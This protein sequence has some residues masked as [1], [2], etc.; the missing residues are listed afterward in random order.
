MEA[1]WRDK[2]SI[3]VWGV[4]EEVQEREFERILQLERMYDLLE[5]GMVVR[6]GNGK[7]RRFQILFGSPQERDA[8]LARL[9]PALQKYR[10]NAVASRD[11]IKRRKARGQVAGPGCE[12]G[13]SA[14][15]NAPAQRASRNAEKRK[16]QRL[17]SDFFVPAVNQ[18][19]LPGPLPRDLLSR[20]V[21]LKRC[22]MLRVATFNT[23][24]LNVK[25][26]EKVGEL[27]SHMELHGI[28][29]CAC[30]ETHQAN[31]PAPKV[32]GY[33]WYGKGHVGF[34]IS[35]ALSKVI[36]DIGCKSNSC[37][38]WIRIPGNKRFKDLYLCSVYMPQSANTIAAKEAFENLQTDYVSFSAKGQVVLLGDFNAH[39]GRP[40]DQNE[41]KYIGD[42]GPEENRN[43][44]GKRLM[45]FL[46]KCSAMSM[47]CRVPT[48]D[49][50]LEY[51]RQDPKTKAQTV[52]DYCIVSEDL[53]ANVEGVSVYK[54][55][56]DSD[57]RMVQMTLRGM[58]KIPRTKPTKV[59]KWRRSKLTK[60][61][62]KKEDAKEADANR[63]KW[64]E[65]LAECRE[66][67]NPAG[68]AGSKVG[69]AAVLN[70]WKIRV[71]KAGDE[72]IGR[73]V[74]IKRFSQK[75][76][77]KEVRAAIDH[78]R[79]IYRQYRRSGDL[80]D[81]KEYW[82]LRS[83]VRKLVARKRK[84]EW[85]SKLLSVTTEFEDNTKLFWSLLT[86]LTG[87]RAAL[88][89]G[90][91]RDAEGVLC[92]DEK[93]RSEAL[94]SFY[95]K[96]G[97]PVIQS[98]TIREDG[99]AVQI[100]EEQFT[101]RYDDE[102]RKEVEDFVAVCSQEQREE[103]E[104][105]HSQPFKL[106]EVRA[107][108]KKLGNGKAT[109][110]DGIPPE[111]LKY[112]GDSMAN[113]LCTL[114]NWILDAGHT[115][116]QWGKALVIL[117]YKKGDPTD[118]GNYRG[119]SLLDVVGKVFTRLVAQRIE[120]AVKDIIVRE[121]AGFTEGK[122][123]TEH[124][125]VLDRI[126]QARKKEGKNTYLFFLDVRK[127]FD[128]VW[129][130]GLLYKLWQAG[131][132]GKL[133]RIIKA[134]YAD[135]FSAILL[136][137]KASR[138][139]KILQGVRQG[140][141]ASPC[142]FKV[143]INELAVEL[144]AMNLGVSLGTSLERLQALLFADDIV[145]LADSLE[146]LQRM[147]DKVAR[148]TRKW[149]FQE[150]LGKCGIMKVLAT[151]RG[152]EAEVEVE[153]DV[154]GQATVEIDVG[155]STCKYFGEDVAVVSKYEY[156]G[157]FFHESGAWKTHAEKVM[158]KGA[159]AINGKWMRVFKNRQLPVK[160]RVKV[161]E[162]VVLPKFMYAT[163]VWY[164]P[165]SKPRDKIETLQNKVA[166]AIL[167]CNIKSSC[168]GTR[169]FLGFKSMWMRRAMRLLSWRGRMVIM[170][171]DCLVS[172][173]QRAQWPVGE[174]W[175]SKKGPKPKSL[176][177]ETDEWLKKLRLVETLERFQTRVDED[178]D[179]P[180]D[181]NRMTPKERFN[182]WVREVK[183]A[184][185]QVAKEEYLEE[186]NRRGS[187]LELMSYCLPEPGLTERFSGPLNGAKLI[188]A[189]F[190]LGTHALNKDLARRVRDGEANEAECIF[191]CNGAEEDV[192]HFLLD[193]KG[194]T[195]LRKKLLKCIKGS[196]WNTSWQD[197]W[198]S[199]S[200]LE[201]AAVLLGGSA[202]PVPDEI[203]AKCIAFLR[204]AYKVR[205][206]KLTAIA[207][208]GEDSPSEGVSSDDEA[209][210]GSDDGDDRGKNMSV[211]EGG[212]GGIDPG[213]CCGGEEEEGSGGDEGEEGEGEKIE[214]EGSSGD[215]SEG[216]GVGR[217]GAGWRG[218]DGSDLDQGD[219]SPASSSDEL[220]RQRRVLSSEVPP[221]AGGDRRRKSSD[222][223]ERWLAGMMARGYNDKLSVSFVDRDA[224]VADRS[225]PSF[226][227]NCFVFDVVG[228]VGDASSPS[229]VGANVNHDRA[230]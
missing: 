28:D 186:A 175:K 141:S 183:V 207:E 2:R 86:E 51:T 63:K 165:N 130:D 224:I 229:G 197:K 132:R 214:G 208:N 114:F 46:R 20:E 15:P 70:D 140:D 21:S 210:E 144:K 49:R 153:V 5:S 42:F 16:N 25:R 219:A 93:G 95:E 91:I 170:P 107:V 4:H 226:R 123:C 23:V 61:S 172:K 34:M 66:D 110:G 138:W 90:P 174:R 41:R 62:N 230:R 10:W 148:Y 22:K 102:F 38:W 212:E 111:F 71:E 215:D 80:R 103:E 89:S 218:E 82:R 29:V 157:V 129:R 171:R 54:T 64:R 216:G 159:K 124:I 136:D 227:T 126:I 181:D 58:K 119:I 40:K 3:V 59:V 199:K 100:G 74:V 225:G 88:C 149:R 26:M 147:I 135:N 53:A 161:W 152:E 12:R 105:A 223:H 196:S 78:R 209:E 11:Y 179:L 45:E 69:A 96:L 56:L 200:R 117:L 160:L 178:R 180:P 98:P 106:A 84:K 202:D 185:N 203:F 113:S 188:N 36:Q 167:H 133:W 35:L 48:K 50:S 9:A 8:Q 156:L 115:P 204:Q 79:R 217:R 131:V 81:L 228:V 168:V 112:G 18:Y 6:I 201:Q 155:C 143:F 33:R 177:V 17:L 222:N 221:P 101:H 67:F 190:R 150:N 139:F 1:N 30:Q 169:A 187:K 109:G 77:D 166:A 32:Q 24:A 104:D 97:L 206:A 37:Q 164:C 120:V 85:E 158:M 57:H 65:S 125:Y 211:A 19:A 52:I 44:N 99:K 116:E 189:R 92:V 184:A 176:E 191:G 43:A 193:C 13:E 75:W 55:D 7:G 121:Q 31:Q 27:T 76:F 128:T 162:T 108:L 47:N 60:R 154:D 195:S 146:D 205:S 182:A 151:K 142:L 194:Y 94:A 73:K 72:A 163:E 173:V 192:C 220:E 145:L 83:K 198:L 137:G 14:P 122:G 87:G 39:C 118:P 68:V 134:M 213:W 127:A